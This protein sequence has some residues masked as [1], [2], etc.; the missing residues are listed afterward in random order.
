MKYFSFAR[1]FFAILITLL[2]SLPVQAA[3]YS[4]GLSV[5]ATAGYNDNIRL[6]Q[7]DKTAVKKY[8]FSPTLT[9]GV[10][11]ET[12]KLRLDSILDFNRFD[13]SEFNS[14]DQ[15]IALSLSHQLERSS[16]D[17]SAK[18]IRSST[19]TSELLTSGRVG[20]KAD[21]SEQYQL[22]LSWTYTLT[23]N[24]L[25]QFSAN[26]ALQDYHSDA[27]IG[28]KN[29]GAEV[30]WFHLINE[31]TKIITA[32]TYS[33]YHSDD[34]AFGVPPFG[35]QSYSTR[36]K[37]NGVQIG[38]DYQL[39]EQSQ[40]TGR[41][42]RSR[43]DTTYPINDKSNV[44]SNPTYLTLAELGFGSLFN[45]ICESIPHAVNQSSTAEIN[46]SW[47]NERQQFGLNTVKESQPTSNGYTVDAIQLGAN[48][49]YLLSELDTIS[50]SISAAR[51]RAID[52]KSSLQNGSIA[53][54][55]YGSATLR[56]QR[57]VD[58]HWFVFTSFQYSEQKYTQIDYQASSRTYSLGIV[59]RPQQWHWSR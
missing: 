52:K 51:N 2:V 48:W 45:A 37:T 16:F 46:W 29:A 21:A 32:L 28:Y 30:D 11:T 44:C 47:K 58:E 6:V 9:F 49:S 7:N 56:Y 25:L 26:Y 20:T 31:R 15:S 35:E 27:Y 13:K 43:S 39:T 38:L 24:N 57:Q 4:A 10:D 50:A 14:D 34:V 12:N 1:C 41:L 54:R 22:A 40:L 23:E 17:I 53:D 33:D 18:L 59:Y 3:D 19:L 42:G 5:G 36:S 8:N 55:D